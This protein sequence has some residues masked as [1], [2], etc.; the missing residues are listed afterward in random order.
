MNENFY[1]GYA[2][3]MT[4]GNKH[5]YVFGTDDIEDGGFADIEND[6]LITEKEEAEELLDALRG[7]CE[8]NSYNNVKLRIEGVEDFGEVEDVEL[9]KGINYQMGD[10]LSWTYNGKDYD[11]TGDFYV[12]KENKLHHTFIAPSGK[13]IEI[14]CNYE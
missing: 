10:Y 12:D 6:M 1:L 2:I 14:I 8:Q 3:E 13:E 11:C 5:S 4:I 9:S 7:Y